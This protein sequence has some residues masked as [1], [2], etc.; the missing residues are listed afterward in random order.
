M[1]RQFVNSRGWLILF[2]VI[3]MVAANLYADCQRTK[4]SGAFQVTLVDGQNLLGLT[5]TSNC[6]IPGTVPRGWGFVESL[7]IQLGAFDVRVSTV[8]RLLRWGGSAT[9]L[10]LMM[11]CLKRSRPEETRVARPGLWN[12]ISEG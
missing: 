6:Y 8:D 9:I 3:L 2:A 4:C 10:G 7:R 12:E 5:A 11:L 1:V